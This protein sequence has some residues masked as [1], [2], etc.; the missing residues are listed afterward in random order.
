MY[1]GAGF[2]G[3][4]DGLPKYGVRDVRTLVN[5]MRGKY[6]FKNNLSLTLRIRHYWSYGEYDYYGDLDAN[7]YIIRDDAFQGIQTLTL[8]HLIPI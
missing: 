6:V 1:N 7:G 4:F 8:M 3:Y 2:A 5:I